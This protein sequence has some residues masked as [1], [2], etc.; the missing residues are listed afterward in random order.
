MTVKIVEHYVATGEG[1]LPVR[2]FD[3]G[4]ARGGLIVFM[5]AFG[6][7]DELDRMCIAWAR[8][9]Y[10]AFLPD[11][12]WRQGCVRFSVPADRDEPFDSAMLQ[13]NLATTMDMTTADTAAIVARWGGEEPGQ[14]S[15]FGTVGYCMGARHALA[16]AARLPARIVSA[17]CLH[18]GRMVWDGP[19]SPHLLIPDVRGRLFLGFAS[20][21]PTCP[22]DH[23][24]LL[25]RT[26]VD[27]GV[28]GEAFR[29]SAEHG[30]MFPD[31]WCWDK[32]AAEE[33]RRRILRDLAA[34]VAGQQRH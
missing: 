34:V 21:D 31:R 10:R 4:P 19:S 32:A 30:W 15:R 28:D 1:D 11:L 23:Q 26:L 12:Y 16:A 13:A 20:D 17:A 6:W 33:A 29:F 7:R 2:V 9:G 8:E 14:C 27:S 22:D 18:G 24:A 25:T 5:D 3:P